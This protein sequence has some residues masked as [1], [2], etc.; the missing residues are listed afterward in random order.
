MV[1][2]YKDSGITWIGSIPKEWKTERIKALFSERN[3]RDCQGKTLLSVSQYFG[4]RPKSETDLADSHIAESYDDYKE[5]RKGDFVMNIMLAWN[6]SYAV[7]DYDGIVSPAYC[8]FKFRKDC[9]KKYFHYLLRTDGY[10][11][12]FKTMSRGVIDSRLRLYPEQ[13]YTFPVIIPS[14]DEQQRIADYLDKK[15][16]EIDGLIELQEQMIAQLTDYKQSVITEAV[17]KGLNQ[18]VEFVPS[19]IE[20]IG[21]VPKGWKVC[22][23]KDIFRLRTGT[24]PKDFETGLDSSELVNW[25]TPSDVAEMNC[26]LNCSERHL[27]KAVIEKE[28][29]EL[30]PAGSLIF[31]GIGASAG[32]IGYAT[33][34]G[35]SNQQITTLIPKPSKC[36]G[37]YSYYYMIAD[38]K[39]IRDNAFFTT[40]PIINNSYL[41]GIKTLLPSLEEQTS[42]ASFLDKKCNEID[43]LITAKQKRIE[44]LKEYKKSVIFEAV[45]GKIEIE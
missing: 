26:E 23:I 35:Y 15:C 34:Q 16:A 1:R 37:K 33:V 19:G 29:I 12:A 44:T 42:I 28:G 27:S 10:P 36:T 8:V 41:S 22:R 32:K 13:F 40:L 7:S 24:T 18:N 17:T 39:R 25:F 21:D 5:V 6:G 43:E 9:C 4:I 11:S 2:E 45:T 38:R 31:V 14:V 20:W 30:S 3:E